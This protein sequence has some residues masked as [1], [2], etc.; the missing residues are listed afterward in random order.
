MNRCFALLTVMICTVPAFCKP[1]DRCESIPLKDITLRG[2]LGERMALCIQNRILAQD[3]SELIQ[4]FQRREETRCWQTEFWGK[5]ATSAVWAY[6]YTRN[7]NLKALLDRSVK[8]LIATQTADGYIGNY[9][10]DS[11]LQQWDIWGRKYTLLGLLAY[12]DATADR[13]VLL[14]A[15]RL[16]DHLLTELGP[17]KADIVKTG[18][19]RGMASSSILEPMVFLYNRTGDKRYLDFAE[20][21]VRQWETPD[22]PRLISKALQGVPVAE[23]FPQPPTWWS[24]ENGRKAYEMMSCYE[25]LLEL[26]RVSGNETHL[27]AV[28]ETVRNILDDEIGVAGS[29]ASLECWYHGRMRQTEPAMHTMET[30]VTLSWMK[31]CLN[32]LRLTRDSQFADQIEI[33][34]YNALL[35]S[36]VPDGSGFSKYTPLVGSRGFGENQCGMS[37]NCCIANGPRAVMLLPQFACMTEKAGILINLYCPGTA[38]VSLPSGRTLIIRQTTDYPV[39][40][41]VRITL[42]PE[43]KEA[44]TVS[45]RIPFWSEKTEVRVNREK[46]HSVQAGTYLVLSRIWKPGDAIRIRFDMRGRIV[47][48]LQEIH[49]HVA[50]MRGPVVLA[51]DSRLDSLD[52]GEVAVPRLDP[53]G[54]IEL[55]PVHPK[56]RPGVWMVF[57]GK[58]ITG[59]NYEGAD[60]IPRALPLCDFASSANTWSTR[61]R[62]RVW[63]P[64]LLDITKP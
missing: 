1:S 42:Q 14:S 32:L 13:S 63:L 4:P 21:I 23:R 30:C 54:Y 17:G 40:D 33:S 8:S 10:V 9:S 35:A 26:Y 16:A 55:T 19:Y 38:S 25:G 11:R 18:N 37:I 2:F 7:P 5:W 24:W 41:S 56:I 20:Y 50:V 15:V 29:G 39:S 46:E 52:I 47:R 58:F 44:F 6:R 59:W 51:R 60:G 3:I 64:Q 49:R 12:Y 36:M 31:L 53:D 22:G 57:Q 28:L 61:S 62:C 45:L 48:S 34:A 27:Q 43:T